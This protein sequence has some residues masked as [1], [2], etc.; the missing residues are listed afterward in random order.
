M[1]VPIS[2]SH[3]LGIDN[4]LSEITKGM[5]EDITH[6]NDNLKFCII[7][8]P[9]VGK[10][11]LINA[12]LG[13]NRSIV[14]DVSGTTRDAIDTDFRYNGEKYTVIDTAGMS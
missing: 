12:L 14:S 1:F 8:R 4:L 10:S 7:G 11:S 3:N 9:N 6:A 13:T 2:G 5:E